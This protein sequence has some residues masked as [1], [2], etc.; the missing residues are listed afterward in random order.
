MRNTNDTDQKRTLRAKLSHPDVGEVG[1][2]KLTFGYCCSATFSFDR[3]EPE[4]RPT[5][6][7][8]ADGVV[9]EAED[10]TKWS[11]FGCKA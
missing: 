9:A 1:E 6:A 10:G 2:G 7:Q 8:L 3:F 4:I 11:L 5:E